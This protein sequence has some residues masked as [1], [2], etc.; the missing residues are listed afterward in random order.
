MFD[1]IATTY[2][3]LC[4]KYGCALHFILA[5]DSN[6]LNLSPIL[7]LSPDL[8]QV[9]EVPTRLN[10]P[11]TL[12]PIITSLKQFYKSPVTK[13]PINP[14]FNSRRKPSDHLVVLMEPVSSEQ[15]AQRREFKVIERRPINSAGLRKFSEWVESCDWSELYRLSEPNAKRNTFK[16]N[17]CKNI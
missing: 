3:F 9:V 1:H 16:A 13:P 6:R 4:S 8:H 11:R 17:C 7:N 14:D 15:Q 5:A 12:D 10:P 2:H